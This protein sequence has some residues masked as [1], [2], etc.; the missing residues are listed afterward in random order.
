MALHANPDKP[1]N[2]TPRD[3]L[4]QAEIGNNVQ[5]KTSVC[6]RP[7]MTSTCQIAIELASWSKPIGS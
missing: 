5:S 3:R 1:L 6:N 7:G 4:D 2:Y